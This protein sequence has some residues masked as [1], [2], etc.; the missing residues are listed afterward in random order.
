MSRKP[1]DKLAYSEDREVVFG[2]SKNV[3]RY[4]LGLEVGSGRVIPEIKYFPKPNVLKKGEEAV[5]AYRDITSRLLERALRLGMDYLQLETELPGAVTSNPKLCSEIVSEQKALME[6]FHDKYDTNLALRVTIADIRNFSDEREFEEGYSAILEAFKTS[7]ESGA[8]VL[9]IESFGGKEVFSQAV[10]R[11]DLAGIIF[12]TGILASLDVERLWTDIDREVGNRA[13]LGGDSAC[14]HANSAMVLA[15]GFSRR[16]IPHVLAAVIRAISAVRTLVSFECGA[17]GPGKDCAYENVI[18]KIITGAPISILGKSSACAHT[19]LIGNI[20]MATCDL[21][22][23]ESIEDVKL[24]GGSGPE[25]C[26]EILYYD[27]LLLNT[28]IR[29]DDLRVLKRLIVNSELYRD[30]QTFILAPRIAFKLAESIVA[31]RNYFARALNV[32]KTAVELL[33]TYSAKLA[34]PRFEERYLK[35]FS[36]ELEALEKV[37]EEKFIKEMVS[38][39]SRLAPTFNPKLYDI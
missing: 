13:L 19:S 24:F 1:Y 32:A 23:N 12:A 29:M 14:A 20:T 9:S 25:V 21:W 15:D 39:Y 33:K 4:G 16:L 7:A 11:G 10:V 38:K 36:K 28:A 27:T 6:E 31:K 22:S 2:Y 26:L 8:D 17:R 34:L 3:L 35:K 30:P 5:K 18:I 37:E